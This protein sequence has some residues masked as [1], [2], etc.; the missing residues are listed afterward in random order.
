[1]R[2]VDLVVVQKR[3]PFTRFVCP[4][5]EAM[6]CVCESHAGVHGMGHVLSWPPKPPCAQEPPFCFLSPSTPSPVTFGQKARLLRP[7]FQT[8]QAALP[9]SSL[10]PP[11]KQNVLFSYS[12]HVLLFSAGTQTNG[13]QLSVDCVVVEWVG[14]SAFSV[15]SCRSPT[16]VRYQSKDA[17]LEEKRG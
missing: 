10:T 3:P 11:Q 12:L 17:P 6:P 13:F 9:V 5:Q 4:W 14:C 7:R 15:H 16:A 8:F 1:M 2:P